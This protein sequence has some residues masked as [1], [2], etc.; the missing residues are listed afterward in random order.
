LLLEIDPRDYE[1]LVAQKRAAAQAA[2]ANLE[3]TRTNFKLAEN[4]VTTA[5]DTNSE[6]QAEADAAQ[7]IATRA[8]TDLERSRQLLNSK[9]ISPQEFDAARA[10]ANSNSANFLAAK[11]LSAAARSAVQE[12]LNQ[13][14]SARSAIDNAEAQVKQ[15]EAELQAAELN[16]S[17]TKIV[18]PAAGRVTHRTVDPGDYLQVG[19]NIF[20]LVPD[21]VYVVANFKETQLRNMRPGQ[22]ASVRVDA[23]SQLSFTGHV[24]SIQAGSGA[25]FSLLPPENAVGNFVKVVQ[26][27]PVKILL[28]AAPDTNHV[29]GPGLSVTPSV[30][31][32]NWNIPAWIL[33][34]IAIFIGIFV[35]FLGLRR[36]TA[37]RDRVSGLQTSPSSA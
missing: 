32:R 19:Q 21:N 23:Y 3:S 27:V 18:A 16:L 28:N 37:A 7:A 15:S 30:R 4:R 1:A 2:L 5:E 12:A 29:L 36:A 25:A 34:V 33:A 13:L 8:Q 20:A 9:T 31:V 35:A 17:Y 14:A 22:P 10:V 11:Q 6:R 26:R 24:D